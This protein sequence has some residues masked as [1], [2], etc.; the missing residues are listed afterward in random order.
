MKSDHGRGDR[1][2]RLIRWR[3]IRGRGGGPEI[4]ERVDGVE[5]G[6]RWRRESRRMRAP[7]LV[8]YKKSLSL[9]Q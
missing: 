3:V 2:D 4:G 7:K 6:R 1:G 9:N 8:K 5:S